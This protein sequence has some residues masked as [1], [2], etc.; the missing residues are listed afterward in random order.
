MAINFK[1]QPAMS[2]TKDLTTL[3]KNPAAVAMSTPRQ[4]GFTLRNRI[5]FTNVATADKKLC[6]LTA[7][8]STNSTD[9]LL[10]LEVPNRTLV[11][12]LISLACLHWQYLRT[13]LSLQVPQRLHCLVPLLWRLLE[14]P[15]PNR[16]QL[17]VY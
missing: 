10:V 14:L 9:V 17:L 3:A 16:I 8:A 12:K 13:R 2:R 7:S 4:G 1:F 6:I 11:H 15:G 5:N